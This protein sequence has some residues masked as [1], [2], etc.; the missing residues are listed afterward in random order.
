M[1]GRSSDNTENIIHLI[2]FGLSNSYISKEG[3]HIKYT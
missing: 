2:D 1:I 3:I